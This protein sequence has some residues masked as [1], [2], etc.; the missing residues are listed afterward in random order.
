MQTIENVYSLG[1]TPRSRIL[2]CMPH[3]D[4]EAVF[5]SGILHELSSRKVYVKVLTFSRG[6]KSTLRYGL[7]DNAS[8][9]EVRSVELKNALKILGIEDLK[10]FDCGDG[11]LEN[12]EK[13][14]CHLLRRE[15]DRY[16]PTH[17][18]TLEPNGIYGHPDHIALSKF[19]SG[20]SNKSIEILYATVSPSFIL[21]ESASKMARKK[22]RPIKPQFELKLGFIGSIKKLLALK[23]HK[24]QFRI[25]VL[26][27]QSFLFFLKN[28]MLTSE[29]FSYK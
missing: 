2:V 22:V 11:N 28:K 12:Q 5:I 6:E 21:P 7:S 15:I 26:H 18:I 14:I 27:P 3:P 8:L 4:D 1:I 13:E 17:L 19:V 29:F 23:S 16:K 20:I 25:D 10:I 9:G 24:S